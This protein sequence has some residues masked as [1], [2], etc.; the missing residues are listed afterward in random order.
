ME[1]YVLHVTH[2]CN[3]DC[4]Y[5][6][7]TKYR[8]QKH[9][10]TIEETIETCKKFAMNKDPFSVEFI[11]GEPCLAIDNMIAA[12][13]W[14]K[15]NS[16]ASHFTITTNGSLIP[17]KLLQW[18]DDAKDVNFAISLDGTKFM[19]QWRVSKG[20]KKGTYDD[21]VANSKVMLEKYG[22]ERVCVHMNI[23]PYNV[24]F[25]CCGIQHLYD[26]GFRSIGVGICESTYIID[27]IFVEKYIKEMK[28][29]SDWIVE[30]N[31]QDVL[32]VSELNNVK[33]LSDVRHYIYD[34]TGK[35]VFESYGRA[36][37]DAITKGMAGRDETPGAPWSELVHRCRRQ[38]YLIHQIN[39][40][41]QRVSTDSNLKYTN[42]EAG[43]TDRNKTEVTE[44]QGYSLLYGD[45]IAGIIPKTYATAFYP[46]KE[47]SIVQSF[48]KVLKEWMIVNNI[49]L[50]RKNFYPTIKP[51]FD[52]SP[53][54]IM[55]DFS[56]EGNLPIYGYV[57]EDEM[58]MRVVVSFNQK[59]DFKSGVFIDFDI[60]KT[61]L[62]YLKRGKEIEM[63][64]DAFNDEV[65]IPKDIYS[66]KMFLAIHD[67]D[68]I[69]SQVYNDGKEGYVLTIPGFT[70]S[71]K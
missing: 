53:F 56:F 55:K 35:P 62:N 25:L 9:T 58:K 33:P 41:R 71:N 6:Y 14:L 37:E 2:S 23:H 8:N 1:Q 3:F 54:T 5:C 49:V 31:L 63:F 51:P 21:V 50:P 61:S 28:K 4:T 19:N 24:G 67:T 64:N 43:I 42:Q 17:E 30:S 16:T 59:Q 12:Y 10:Y 52:I 57:N 32:Y 36:N 39:L 13:K 29:V 38:S 46:T 69:I 44:K 60:D 65:S 48:Y 22:S 27:D 18:L 15:E 45:T 20:M 66:I 68:A 34:E 47:E 40:A 11:G 7:D 26:I 70:I